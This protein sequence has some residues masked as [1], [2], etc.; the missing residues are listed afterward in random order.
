M[1]EK[2]ASDLVTAIEGRFNGAI[3]IGI[4]YMM[5]VPNDF[6]SEFDIKIYKEHGILK[7]IDYDS[8]EIPSRSEM[9]IFR[10]GDKIIK[11]VALS[12]IT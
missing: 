3:I 1:D 11:E 6:I 2:T 12:D 4:N 8:V 7:Y 5:E 9:I 10:M